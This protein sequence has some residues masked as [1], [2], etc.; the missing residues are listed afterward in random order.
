MTPLLKK[1]IRLLLPAWLAVVVIE[2]LVPWFGRDADWNI[3]AL[4]PIALFFG[5]IL[6]AV[7]SFGREFSLGTFS[8]LMVQPMDRRQMWQTKTTLL[9]VAAGL[10]FCANFISCQWRLHLAITARDSLWTG[11]NSRFIIEDSHHAMLASFVLLFVALTG[12]LWTTLLLRQMAAAFWI[13]LMVPVGLMLMLALV[14]S[15][16]FKSVPDEVGLIIIYS[17]ATVYGFIGFWFAHRLFFRAQDT[18]WSGGVISLDR[19]RYLEGAASDTESRRRHRPV[20]ALMQKEFQLNSVSLFCA[21]ALLVLHGVVLAWRVAHA[22]VQPHSSLAEAMDYFWVMWLAMPLV[23]SCTTVAE[24]RKLG[25]ADSQLCLP[26][27]RRA[28]FFIKFIP[29]LAF[30]VLLGGVVPV[31]LE[32]LAS[33]LGVP[34][35]SFQPQNHAPTDFGDGMMLFRFNLLCLAAGL[36]LA[37]FLAST[38]ARN[39]L[40]ALSIAIIAIVVGF[41]GYPYLPWPAAS[42]S[43][44]LLLGVPLITATLL[45]VGYRAFSNYHE[46]NRLWWRF[47]LVVFGAWILLLVLCPFIYHRPWERLRPFEPPH[48]PARWTLNQ[49]PVALRGDWWSGN[50]LVSL[51]DGRFWA[52]LMTPGPSRPFY[53]RTLWALRDHLFNAPAPRLAQTAFLDGTNWISLVTGAQEHRLYPGDQA[54]RANFQSFTSQETLGI[55]ADGTLWLSEKSGTSPWNN[56]PFVQFGTDTHWRQVMGYH[57]PFGVVLL[58]SDGTVWY[59]GHRDGDGY[60]VATWPGLRAFT[61]RQFATNDDWQTLL[62]LGFVAAQKKDGSVW[63]IGFKNKSE[64][65]DTQWLPNF[66]DRQPQPEP[67]DNAKLAGGVL[68]NLIARIRPDGTLWI[69]G[70]LHWDTAH[71]QIGDEFLRCSPDTNWVSVALGSYVMVA[72][73]SDGT[74]WRWGGQ[75]NYR[76]YA[77]DYTRPPEPLG[78]HSDWVALMHTPE[79]V[80]SLAADGSLWLWRDPEEYWRTPTRF[81]APSAKPVPLGNILAAN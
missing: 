8:S 77:D 15:Q 78:T 28:L 23:I 58:K 10:V 60:S 36:S 52:G 65:P 41:V 42:L 49:P 3:C 25:V 40:H 66:P 55:R 37:A 53:E 64:L 24:E 50:L 62:N 48:G 33:G 46:L 81:L 13:T 26:V 80:V 6:L 71:S 56:A 31:L 1:E 54:Y 39:F 67:L 38:F 57:Y 74:L 45:W 69:W 72:L 43:L 76:Q 18:G 11:I 16:L 61:P 27:S 14:M 47:L 75:P 44:S 7:D 63:S 35:D 70:H 20:R 68:D 19:W 29:A 2:A 5:I 4:T 21:G 59:W 9:L 79:G 30:G 34:A 73:K 22:H 17:L 51:P 12:G 32:S